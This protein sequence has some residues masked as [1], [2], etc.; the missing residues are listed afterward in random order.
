[1][2]EVT[3]SVDREKWDDFVSNHPEGNIFQTCAMADVY[4][5]TRNYEPISLA[6]VEQESGEILAVLQTVIIRDAPGLVGSISSRSII[7]GGPLFVEVKKGFEA[8]QKL[9]SYYE[10][11]L[12]NRAIYTQVRNLWGTESSKATL[13]SLG[14]EYEPHLNYL[15]NLDRHE[16]EIW[17]DIHKTR[18][19]GINR[20]EKVG[21]E[22][23]K[24]KNR[25]EIKDCYKVIEE[26]YKNVRL[27]LADISLLESA[28][29]R[30]SDS[31]NIDFYL[32]ILEGE[33]VGSRVVLKYK[34]LVHDWYAGSKQ[35][36]NYVNEAVVWH[37]LS[38]YAGKEKV[39][40]FGGAGNPDK[41]Y[42][43][44]EFKKRFGGEEVNFGRYEK[45]HDRSK[46]EL[47]NLGFKAYKKL[48]LARV[49]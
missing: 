5:S 45:V 47:L 3:D 29:D 12:N 17:G 42:G 35:E 10:K 2:I 20:A 23:R 43:V 49:F 36:I 32:A 48:N 1:M 28:Y 7:N 34:G 30:L 14:Y 46:K 11:F 8:L 33:V 22:V 44:R 27:P 4:R 15:I 40:D 18:R 41:P 31:G 21:I 9:L 16:K 38:E 39:F 24:I 19:K 6:T 26:T 13:N 37:M 25:D